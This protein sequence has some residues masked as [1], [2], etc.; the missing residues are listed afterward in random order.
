[1]EKS[2]RKAGSRRGTNIAVLPLLFSLLL[3]AYILLASRDVVSTDYIR[4]VNSYLPE[5]WDIKKLLTADILTRIPISYLV[6][7]INLLMFGYSVHFDRMLGVLGLFLSALVIMDYTRRMRTGSAMSFIIMAVMFS[8]NKWE[9]LLNGSGYAHFL[10]F[11]IFYL[12]YLLIERWYQG[13][14]SGR[15]RAGLALLPWLSLMT[16]GPYLLVY[17]ISLVLI[18]AYA[19]IGS[20]KNIKRT[21]CIIYTASALITLFLYMLSNHFA[22]YEYAGAQGVALTEVL[23]EYPAFTVHFILNGLASMLLS[24][25]LMEALLSRGLLSM[26]AIYILGMLVGASYLLAVFMYISR[27]LYKR[28]VFPALLMLYGI[29]SHILVFLSRYIFMRETYAWQS[30]YSL[31]YQSGILGMLL[32]FSLCI[33]SPLARGGR[34]A[35]EK[36]V[37]TK[38]LIPLLSV[39]F[40]LGNC[41][42]SYA[43]IKKIPNRALRYEEMLEAGHKLTEYT[44]EALENIFEYHHGGGRIRRAYGILEENGLSIFREQA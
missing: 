7:S 40:L 21:D 29:G 9:M 32:I 13:T 36:K 19:G 22:V 24:G 6:R 28:T 12:H 25:E 44:D 15:G 3:I 26:R 43:E 2:R 31:Q 10:A 1:M 41:Y 20:N 37:L 35:G 5:P 39:A 8:L 4:L 11:F 23:L 14:I 30:R 42:T 33:N 17:S 34:A 16:A 38:V 18:Y 27:R